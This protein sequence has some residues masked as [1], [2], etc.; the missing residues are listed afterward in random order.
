MQRTRKDPEFRSCLGLGMELLHECLITWCQCTV[1]GLSSV[2]T[3]KG[4]GRA[5]SH[6]ALCAHSFLHVCISQPP[7]TFLSELIRKS[8]PG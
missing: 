7:L 3:V 4:E 1:R 6:K 2:L 8:W 5:V